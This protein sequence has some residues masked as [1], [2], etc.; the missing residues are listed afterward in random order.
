MTLMS[1]C[2]SAVDAAAESTMI[3]SQRAIEDRSI[4]LYRPRRIA[5]DRSADPPGSL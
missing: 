4:S 3:R 2:A 5:D 1:S